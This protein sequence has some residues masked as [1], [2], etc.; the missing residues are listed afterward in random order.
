MWQSR[1]TYLDPVTISIFQKVLSSPES[2]PIFLCK[3][4]PQYKRFRNQTAHFTCYLW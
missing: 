2:Q 3:I 4:V 1:K